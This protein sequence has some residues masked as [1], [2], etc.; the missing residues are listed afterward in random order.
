MML[1]E[2]HSLIISVAVLNKANFRVNVFLSI[3]TYDLCIFTNVLVVKNTCYTTVLT[4]GLA[5]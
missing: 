4:E 2:K 5:F 1:L 3:F